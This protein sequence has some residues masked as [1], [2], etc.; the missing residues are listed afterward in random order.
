MSTGIDM[1]EVDRIKQSIER[2]GK[3][4]LDRIYTPLE[5]AYCET[6]KA[7]RFQ[8][9]AAR[10]AAKE[11]VYKFLQPTITISWTDIEV[12]NSESG[13]PSIHISDKLKPLAKTPIHISLSH[14]KG[15]AVAVVTSTTE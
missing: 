13:A 7:A 5:Q 10:F 15:M 6:K 11:A 12:R 9:Y 3:R 2:W 1:V 14:T 8:S 4:F